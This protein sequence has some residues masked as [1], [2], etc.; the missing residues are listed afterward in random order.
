MPTSSLLSA[1]FLTL[2]TALGQQTGNNP[3]WPRWCGKVYESGYPSFNPGGQAVEP[4]HDPN[5][6]LLYV[7]VAPRYNLYLDSETDGEFV[8]RTTL[9]P[10]F[11]SALPGNGNATAKTM[12]SNDTHRD[13]H[14]SISLDSVSAVLAQGT[15]SFN[16]TSDV[17][18]QDTF[19]PFSL[20]GLT[21]GTARQNVTLTGWIVSPD[22]RSNVSYSA[23]SSGLVYLPV[24]TGGG[25]VTRLDN[26]YGGFWHLKGGGGSSTFEPFF[27]YGFYSSYDGFLADVSDNATAASV[28]GKYADF[29]LN[30]MTPL[31]Q[32]PTSATA[33]QY[34][35]DTDLRFQFDLREQYTN[36]TWVAEQV[37][38]AKDNAALFSYWSSDEPDGHQDPFSAPKDCRDTIRSV[39]PYHPVALV[40]NCQNYYFA[41]YTEGSA[42]VIMEDVYPIGINTTWSKWGT[43]CN[44]TLGDC[45][46]DNCEGGDHAVRD[47]GDRLDDL[48]RYESYI[49]GRWPATK[50]HN[51]QSFNG[52]GYWAR[53]PT[54]DE[55]WAMTLVAVNHGAKGI[56]SWVYPVASGD[57][58]PAAHG[59][60]A[61]VLTA[62]PVVDF[63]VGNAAPIILK[64]ASAPEVDIA[65]WKRG[66]ELL[67]S[68]VN[69]G[70]NNYTSGGPREIALPA[71]YTSV[72]TTAWGK[73]EW[74]LS[75][76][77]LSAQSIP[78]LSTSLLILTA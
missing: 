20:K 70:Y 27:P 58:L 34:M 47:V 1:L 72:K 12:Y 40:L 61:K 64:I 66:S 41:E 19:I 38:A 35:V 4:A 2:H 8:V 37:A 33:F 67:V 5:G 3:D 45:G 10:Y 48:F 46:C 57:G 36:S 32:Y 14:Y 42:D 26:A 29:G 49:E 23:T 75:G 68:I 73:L 74:S 6:P 9:S 51:P 56:I 78:A 15:A 69:S 50:I 30:A 77:T 54:P 65:C 13:L 25:S 55:E 22:G 16:F 17:A 18:T 59:Q 71:L 24:P 28:I 62:S 31:S 60:L 63:I 44:T 52:E 39:D 21:S 43:T 7:Q 53:D 76:S 11:G